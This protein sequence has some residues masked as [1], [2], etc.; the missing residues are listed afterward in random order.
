MPSSALR[1]LLYSPPFPY[2]TLFRSQFQ[3]GADGRHDR[4]AGERVG[5]LEDAVAFLERCVSGI[6]GVF[7]LRRVR[8][9]PAFARQTMGRLLHRVRDR[10]STRLNSSH[11]II[12]YAVFCFT[13]SA[14]FSTLSLHDA[15]PISIPV[16][17]RW[18]A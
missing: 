1:A 17:R 5:V 7:H 14:L 12:S 16:G 9:A 18:S 10:K 13:R 4:P 2:T 3:S 6:P 15:L 8:P 11:Q